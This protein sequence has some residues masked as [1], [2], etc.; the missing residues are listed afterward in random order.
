MFDLIWL[1]IFL[2]RELEC[3]KL[4]IDY[5]DTAHQIMTGKK[6]KS[7]DYESLSR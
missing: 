1:K 3:Q 5:A 6:K 4:T 7:G 2:E